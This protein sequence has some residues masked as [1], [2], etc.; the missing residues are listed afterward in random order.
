MSDPSARPSDNGPPFPPVP[1]SGLEKHGDP[2]GRTVG[3][4]PASGE[5]RLPNPDGKYLTSRS[6]LEH[7]LPLIRELEAHGGWRAALDFA[8]WCAESA[9]WRHSAITPFL[10]AAKQLL[11][12][13]AARVTVKEL[14]D[15][16]GHVWLAA[17]LI[18]L[19][20]GDPCAASYLGAFACIS[21]EPREAAL[22]GAQ[23]YVTGWVLSARNN[24]LKAS[25]PLPVTDEAE[26]LAIRTLEAEL[27]RRLTALPPHAAS[28][29]QITPP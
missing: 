9:I 26:T 16:N 18:G 3:D 10:D 17:G 2:P 22:V 8:I 12:D 23:M 6:S 4:H 7:F 19:K 24:A 27:R 21:Q 14:R 29:D 20:I 15:K 1:P 11:V 5:N 25:L 13:E 28:P